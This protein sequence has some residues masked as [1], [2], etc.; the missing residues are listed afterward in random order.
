MANWR[1]AVGSASQAHLWARSVTIASAP[2][3]PAG[4]QNSDLQAS[5]DLRS[6]CTALHIIITS[7]FQPTSALQQL[8]NVSLHPCR[9][10]H[11]SI[12]TLADM[13]AAEQDEIFLQYGR[14]VALIYMCAMAEALFW[15][16]EMYS[17]GLVFHEI[18]AGLCGGAPCGR[19]SLPCVRG[20]HQLVQLPH[21]LLALCR[22]PPSAPRLHRAHIFCSITCF[23]ELQVAVN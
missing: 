7:S 17:P 1:L 18:H 20:V 2:S 11:P 6:A 4:G 9:S 23:L 12:S 21:R 10:M 15:Q 8:L 22:P 14:R 3:A 16:G 13:G 19:R 5:I